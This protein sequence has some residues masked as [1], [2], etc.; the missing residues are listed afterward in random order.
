MN[1]FPLTSPPIPL[2]EYVLYTRL[3]ADNYGRPIM[4]D[5][6]IIFTFLFMKNKLHILLR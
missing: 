2:K 4:E 3:N 6:L 5:A 1:L